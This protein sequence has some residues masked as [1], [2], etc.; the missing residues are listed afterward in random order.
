VQGAAVQ[1][2]TSVT[3]GTI[4]ATFGPDATYTGLQDGS[5]HAAIYLRQNDQGIQDEDQSS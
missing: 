4:I 5:A 3:P 1:G 2:N